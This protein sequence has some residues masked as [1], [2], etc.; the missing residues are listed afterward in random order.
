MLLAL[1]TACSRSNSSV[2]YGLIGSWKVT[3][4]G[5]CGIVGPLPYTGLPRR[6]TLQADNRYSRSYHDS[7]TESGTYSLSRRSPIGPPDTLIT[8]A[9]KDTS[10]QRLLITSGTELVLSVFPSSCESP[11]E[12]MFQ[13]VP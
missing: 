11:M 5:G 6:L 10:Y 4:S 9:N 13:K 7:L 1:L 12:E 8:F 2:P 3:R